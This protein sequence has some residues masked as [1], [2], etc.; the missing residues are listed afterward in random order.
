MTDRATALKPFSWQDW[1]SLIEDFQHGGARLTKWTS[2]YSI[3]ALVDLALSSLLK[4]DFPLKIPLLIFLEEYS[5][6]LFSTPKP[7]NPSLHRLIEALR[8]AVQSPVDN[9]HI[10]FAFKEQFMI[11]TTCILISID[12]FQVFDVKYVENVVELLLTVINRPNHGFDRHTRAIAAECL[13]Q[14]EI[15]Y[16][17]LLSDIAAHLWTLCQSE[18]THASQSYILLFTAVVYNIVNLKLNVSILNTSVP[19]V[20]FSVPQLML[21]SNTG[22]NYKE[23]RKAMAFFLESQQVFTPC[24]MLELLGM[25]M[26]VAVA[27]ELQPSMLKVQFFGMIYSFDPVLCHAVLMMYLN[28]FDAFDGQECEIAKRF[29]LVSKETQHFLVFRLLSVHWLLGLL[30][31]L[32]LSIEV[33]KK[34]AIV[35]LGLRIHLSVFDPLALKSLKL[36]LLAFCTIFLDILK[37]ESAL[38]GEIGEMKSVVKLFEDGLVSVSALKWL[39]PTSTET[40]VAFRTFHKFLIGASSHS[41]IDPSTTRFLM[42]ST[43]FHALQYVYQFSWEVGYDTILGPCA[44]NYSEEENVI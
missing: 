15:S 23:L 21:G 32:M 10:T 4:K 44:V 9:F 42:D 5:L 24:G 33:G 31:K 28:F 20:P 1:E 7:Q 17:C 8:F 2:D 30:N 26:P 43:I 11:S 36:D 29:M 34:K 27:L 3:T 38:D 25:I 12:A 22:L 13:R 39:P 19:L 40:A 35:E 16:P 41:N 37:S 6:T 14:L 18:R